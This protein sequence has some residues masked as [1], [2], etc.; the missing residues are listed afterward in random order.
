MYN[1]LCAG[2]LLPMAAAANLLCNNSHEAI[3]VQEFDTAWRAGQYLFTDAK[4]S[5]PRLNLLA[6]IGRSRRCRVA[7]QI[8]SGKWTVHL[9]LS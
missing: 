3:D 7:S 4:R 9:P 6:I 8:A 2:K 5:H 1:S